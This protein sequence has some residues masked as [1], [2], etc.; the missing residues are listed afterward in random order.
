MNP[1]KQIIINEV[2]DRIQNSPF[3]IVTDYSGITVDQFTDLRQKLREA[4]AP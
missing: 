3:V 4:G 1:D 2:L